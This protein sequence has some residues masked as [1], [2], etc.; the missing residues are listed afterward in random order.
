[1]SVQCGDGWTGHDLFVI[2]TQNLMI[3][4]EW[5]GWNDD[6]SHRGLCH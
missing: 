2:S 6:L 4:K 1:M 5:K 3:M